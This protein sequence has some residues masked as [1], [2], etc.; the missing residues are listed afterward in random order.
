M[1]PVEYVD[2]QVSLAVAFWTNGGQKHVD[3]LRTDFPLK[4]PPFLIP[5]R[6]GYGDFCHRKRKSGWKRTS[7]PSFCTHNT[8]YVPLL[9]YFSHLSWGSFANHMQRNTPTQR[10]RIHSLPCQAPLQ[11]NCYYWEYF[12][13]LSCFRKKKLRTL[14]KQFGASDCF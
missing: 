14:D 5:P 6:K 4:L 8:L 7:S 3:A 11:I 1:R 12:V 9:F 10:F 13:S 2:P